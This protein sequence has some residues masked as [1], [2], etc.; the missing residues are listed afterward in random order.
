MLHAQTNLRNYLKENISRLL[1]I[2]YLHEWIA[3]NLDYHES[4]RL[5]YILRNMQ[6]LANFDNQ[7]I[8]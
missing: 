8:K 3:S 1:A 5:G 4:E 6:A 7:S 2:P